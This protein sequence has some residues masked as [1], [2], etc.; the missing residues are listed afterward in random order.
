M[1]K[2][3]NYLIEKLKAAGIK[4][5]VYTSMKKLKLSSET[6]LAAVLHNRDV[7][8]RTNSKK[9]YIDQEGD[10]RCRHTYLT[11]ET[12][13][14]VV[15]SDSD[16]EKCESLLN[17]FLMMLDK[18]LGVDENWVDIEL[19]EAEWIEKDDSILKAKISVELEV[20]FKGIRM[21]QDTKIQKVGIRNI[22]VAGGIQHAGKSRK[23]DSGSNNRF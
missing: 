19:G 20:K 3:R 14:N 11:K 17:S 10:E 8:E 4:S 12:S 16:E 2:E 15:I 22:N 18:G 23:K 13:F 1:I 9:R 21:Y 7:F 6:H 5:Q